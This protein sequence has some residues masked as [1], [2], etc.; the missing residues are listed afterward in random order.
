APDSALA[1]LL[2]ERRNRRRTPCTSRD[3]PSPPPR[4][5]PTRTPHTPPLGTSRHPKKCPP[6]V[7]IAPESGTPRAPPHISGTRRETLPPS[8][9]RP[10]SPRQSASASIPARRT[11]PAS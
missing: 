7:R 2:A 1:P 4:K 8:K 6:A 9:P 11:P 5:Q 3:P 10:A